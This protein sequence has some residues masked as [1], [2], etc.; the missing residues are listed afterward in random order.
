LPAEIEGGQRTI[1]RLAAALA[2]AA[3]EVKEAQETLSEY[4]GRFRDF[5]KLAPPPDLIDR[6]ER[7]RRGERLSTLEEAA[8]RENPAAKKAALAYVEKR[9]RF[10]A[11]ERMLSAELEQ[12]RKAYVARAAKLN[13]ARKRSTDAPKELLASQAALPEV[14]KLLATAEKE[15]GH[16]IAER[17]RLGRELAAAE[18]KRAVEIAEA[19]KRAAE[20]SRRLAELERSRKA[21]PERAAVAAFMPASPPWGS[22]QK[23]G[24]S[25]LPPVVRTLILAEAAGID[26]GV[27]IFPEDDPLS[28]VATIRDAVRPLVPAGPSTAMHADGMGVTHRQ[29][30]QTLVERAN[31]PSA[32]YT[33]EGPWEAVQ[34]SNGVF[35][36]RYYDDSRGITQFDFVNPNAGVRT[37][38]EQPYLG[39]DFGQGWSQQVPLQ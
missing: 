21:Q 1:P 19:Q 38:G 8:W 2:A 10:D 7:L 37:F 22:G 20:E 39:N 16:L 25:K 3:S 5:R 34:F 18:S 24:L 26:V 14:S 4:S 17:D 36:R 27:D 15:M 33:Q 23:S 12:A 6:A 31:G 30:N 28:P 32:L 13:A 9:D 29:G 11:N 35:G